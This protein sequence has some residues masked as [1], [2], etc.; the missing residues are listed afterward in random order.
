[1]EEAYTKTYAL[2]I[3]GYYIILIAKIY[4]SQNAKDVYTIQ[5]L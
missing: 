1:M 4:Y 2:D 5:Y 3:Y